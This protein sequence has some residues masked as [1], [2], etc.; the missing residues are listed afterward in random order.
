MGNLTASFFC[1]CCFSDRLSF[2][3][4]LSVLQEARHHLTADLQNKMDT[5]DIDLSCLS[6][7]IKSSQISLKTNP[8]RIPSG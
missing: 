1:F 6:L 5:L 8:T 2:V 3:L 4:P 7:T